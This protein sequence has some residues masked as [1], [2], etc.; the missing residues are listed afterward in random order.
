MWDAQQTI[1]IGACTLGQSLLRIFRH[2]QTGGRVFYRSHRSQV[3][4]PSQRSRYVCADH[5]RA[6]STRS[7][8]TE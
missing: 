8:N 3:V 1:K 4:R 6:K 7:K 5:P 2:T